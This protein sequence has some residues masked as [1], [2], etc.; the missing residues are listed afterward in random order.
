MYR[1]TFTGPRAEPVT[2][3]ELLPAMPRNTLQYNMINQET[4]E[5]IMGRDSLGQFGSKIQTLVKHLLYLKEYEP[6][7]KSI[8]FS[9]WSDSLELVAYALQTNGITFLRIDRANTKKSNPAHVFQTDPTYQVLLLHG[10][11]LLFMVFTASLLTSFTEN[12][13]MPVSTSQPH[14]M[15]SS[16]SRLSIIPSR[17]K[18]CPVPWNTSPSPTHFNPPCSPRSRRPVGRPR[19]RSVLLFRRRHC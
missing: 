10:F 1:I 5:Q 16:W 9:A 6:D 15:F 8:V 12:E 4:L 11:V 18:V 14:D 3:D 2:V 19:H 7:S 17:F 13:T